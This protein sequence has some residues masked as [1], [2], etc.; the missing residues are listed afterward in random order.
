MNGWD[1]EKNRYCRQQSAAGGSALPPGKAAK[2]PAAQAPA[3]RL[4]V[5]VAL[6]TLAAAQL[7]G[8]ALAVMLQRMESLAG[9]DDGA[10]EW[11]QTHP[12]TSNRVAAIDQ[13]M[14]ALGVVVN[15]PLQVRWT[16]LQAA[17]LAPREH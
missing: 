17:L 11:A 14:T 5:R 9:G 6:T 13:E 1:E 12:D 15:T 3:V 8:R 7:D 2:A 16:E 4:I 10:P